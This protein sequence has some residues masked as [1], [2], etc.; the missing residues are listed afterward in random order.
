MGG[1][2]VRSSGV[3][4]DVGCIVRSLVELPVVEGAFSPKG[5]VTIQ[6]AATASGGLTS[7]FVS[8]ISAMNRLELLKDPERDL[9]RLFMTPTLATPAPAFG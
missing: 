6:S 7:A 5:N 1:L 3:Y 9:G 8:S 4:L 2:G